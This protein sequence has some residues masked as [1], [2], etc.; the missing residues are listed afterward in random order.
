MVCAKCNSVIGD[1]CRLCTACGA[2]VGFPNVRAAHNDQELS[3]LQ[4]RWE[5]AR[6]FA[7]KMGTDSTVQKFEDLLKTSKAVMCRSWGIVDRIVSA[8]NQVFAT[9]YLEVEAGLRTPEDN[10][11]DRIRAAVD[12]TFFPYYSTEIRFAALTLDGRGPSAYGPCSI[13]LKESMIAE[14]ATVFEE[15]TVIFC[16]RRGIP[17]GATIPTG[18]RAQWE[19]R[20]R[21]CIAKLHEKIANDMTEGIFAQLLLQ[22]QPSTEETELIEVHIYGPINRQ[23]IEAVGGQQPTTEEDRV[24]VA[25]IKRKL[26]QIGVPLVV[27]P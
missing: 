27:F 18:H 10:E 17:L 15:N 14:R 1:H 5:T 16:R 6:D 4:A 19:D 3:A 26:A 22:Q 12:A 2:D 25:S 21:L 23:A 7:R 9:F 8:D 11:M 13:I 24:I 20:H